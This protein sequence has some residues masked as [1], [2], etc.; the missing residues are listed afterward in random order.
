[1]KN[2]EIEALLGSSRGAKALI[3]G[4][5][6]TFTFDELAREL[7]KHFGIIATRRDEEGVVAAFEHRRLNPIEAEISEAI[8]ARKVPSFRLE[9]L[10]ALIA[11]KLQ[12][13][14]VLMAI[15]LSKDQGR[16]YRLLGN[17][18]I[19]EALFLGLLKLYEWSGEEDDRYDRDV[20]MYTLRRYLEIKPNETDLLYSYHT[21]RRL[22]EKSNHAEL[23]DALLSFPNFTF[24]KRGE[25]TTLYALIAQN[26]AISE[27][28]IKRL[29]AMRD[30]RIDKALAANPVC[31]IDILKYYF[32]K[33]AIEIDYALASN[34]AIDDTIFEG[35]LI[36]GDT[37]V[38]T[39]L[40][41]DQPL[42]IARFRLIEKQ[43]RDRGLLVHLS[44]NERLDEALKSYL[45]ETLEGEALAA[46]ASNDTLTPEMLASIYA[47][48]KSDEILY[49]LALNPRTP[50]EI[51]SELYERIDEE[52]TIALHLAF[53]PATEATVLEQLFKKAKPEINEGLAK[54][55]ATPDAI[56]EALRLEG[57]YQN[58]LAENPKLIEA[59]ERVFD[60]DAKAIL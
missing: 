1:M 3:L 35:L 19:D 42:N 58:A 57:H 47:R 11:G 6:E 37:T 5:P 29:Q 50:K 26:P 48:D 10:E 43:I 32:D 14:S 4:R 30:E 15:T 12:S 53:N 51:L 31:G 52:E 56:L 55:P 16:I 46:I 39:Y 17:P 2:K 49:A 41:W 9:A 54:N 38:Q 25:E 13:K 22:V 20:I 60:Y 21:L 45:C 44:Q 24:R 59:Y 33:N 27:A 7:Q 34:P 40:L 28:T 36:R 18:H 23:L 8:Y